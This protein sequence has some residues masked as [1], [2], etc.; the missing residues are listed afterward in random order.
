MAVVAI[1]LFVVIMII[2]YIVA[3]VII[4]KSAVA[5][6]GSDN[7]DLQ[8]AHKWLSWATSIT[9]ISVFLTII[10]LVIAIIAAVFF[11]PVELTDAVVAGVASA[12]MTKDIK[13]A[14][15]GLFG[16]QEINDAKGFV[17]DSL[18]IVLVLVLLLVTFVGILAAV[19]T[20][21]IFISGDRTAFWLSF[22]GAVVLAIPVLIVLVLEIANASYVSKKRKV[23]AED[24]RQINEYKKRII[25]ENI[26]AKAA[27]NKSASATQ[28]PATQSPPQAAKPQVQS[29]QPPPVQATGLNTAPT[30]SVPG[31]QAA[32]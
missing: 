27:A 17:N 28:Q 18:K 23:A 24:V 16:I 19:G 11:A 8:K 25:E 7:T 26:Q 2:A 9:W 15:R 30:T 22:W 14:Q 10:L 3:G 20:W 29:S 1:V 12:A 21:Y 31:Q 4:S 32:V 13:D 5:V 6:S